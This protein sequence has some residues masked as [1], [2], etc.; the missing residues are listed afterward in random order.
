MRTL[1]AILCFVAIASVTWAEK[2]VQSIDVP[3]DRV[4]CGFGYVEYYW[5]FSESD[6]GFT[7]ETCDDHGVTVW[8]Y[9][10]WAGGDRNCWITNL[11]GE[12]PS[13][14]G[15]SLVS[16]NFL[17]D[18]ASF[19]VQ[20]SHGYNIETSYDGANL[21]VNGVVVSPMEGYPDDEISDSDSYYAWCVDGEPG[22]TGYSGGEPVYSCFDLS[23]FMDQEVQL[24]FDFGSDSSVTYPGWVIFSIRVGS[25]VVATEKVTWSAVKGM[26]R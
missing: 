7:L 17:V 19:L 8:E 11:E 25:S 10:Y 1:L 20:I 3:G 2:P 13:D 22:F 9:G 5:D 6:C 4:E 23:A 24:S 12:Y 14:A 26:Y 15:E 21:S 18:S 16:P